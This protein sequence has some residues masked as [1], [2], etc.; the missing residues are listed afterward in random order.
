MTPRRQRRIVEVHPE[1]CFALMLGEPCAAP[2]RAAE[3]R[4]QRLAAITDLYPDAP[5]RIAA[6]HPGAALDDLLDAYALTVTARRLIE[7]SVERLGDGARD[8]RGLRQ[9]VVM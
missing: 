9:E 7:G 3:G 5:Q 6:P 4:A 8:A 1:L 2:K